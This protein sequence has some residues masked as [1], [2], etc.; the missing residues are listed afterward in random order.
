MASRKIA[1]IIGNSKYKDKTLSQLIT[2][3]ADVQALA[4][5]LQS[6]QI[7]GFEEV[8]Q[9]INRSAADVQRAIA[10]FFSGKKPGDVLLLY[11]SGHG[12]RDDR[13]DLYLALRDTESALLSGT[14]IPA[15]FITAEMDRSRSKRQ[16]LILDCCHSGAFS[17]GMKGA[18]GSSV[19]T[20]TV[21]E[22]TGSGRVV[23]TA[24]DSTQ[25][26]WEGEK[27]VGK[28][29]NS[30]FTRYLIRGLETGEADLDGDGNVGLD[31]LYDYVYE[32]V[33]E[34]TPKQTPGKWSYKQHGEFVIARNPFA[35]A[36]GPGVE[37]APRVASE[38]PPAVEKPG[39][40]QFVQ[41]ASGV[42]SVAI[43][44]LTAVASGLI[45]SNF[46]AR[47][48]PTPEQHAKDAR[49][50][51]LE[52]KSRAMQFNANVWAD[53]LFGLAGAMERRADSAYKARSFQPALLGFREANSLFRESQRVA[54]NAIAEA[55]KNIEA[56]RT[57]VASARGRAEDEQE[58]AR[59]A[60]A[61]K[62]ATGQFRIGVNLLQSA[63]SLA[64]ANSA[65]SLRMAL[66]E[67][68]K[69]RDAFQNSIR[70]LEAA[71]SLRSDYRTALTEMGNAKK[72]VPGTQREKNF[73]SNFREGEASEKAARLQFQ[74]GNLQAAAQ[75]LRDATAA[76]RTAAASITDT[77]RVRLR[78]KLNQLPEAGKKPPLYSEALK[79]EQQ[80]DA[81]GKKENFQPAYE[82]Y[83]AALL[84]LHTL[85]MMLQQQADARERRRKKIQNAIRQIKESFRASVHTGELQ[86]LAALY[87]D[88]TP[89]LE[90]KWSLF[91]KYTSARNV[92]IGDVT[93]PVISENGATLDI[94]VNLEYKDTKN[95]LKSRSERYSWSLGKQGGKWLIINFEER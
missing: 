14:A 40:Q 45:Y 43:I 37:K 15:A 2:P 11:F 30:V 95:K 35:T 46:F 69:A 87:A 1:L 53:S 74:A 52:T 38:A 47:N 5:V 36:L 32:R 39:W 83:E 41:S 19:G 66:Q 67:F 25:Y 76:Y 63:K 77:M 90:K 71:N 51:M 54:K 56:L 73:D 28:G 58:K 61:A 13:G 85:S 20:A 23:L 49:A 93:P 84:K 88:F 22:G 82:K 94:V 7:G 8:E 70:D 24:T 62:K 16:V 34:E 78:A 79:L 57:Q 44:L 9:L 10:R 31:E 72:L 4:K 6:H 80:G 17:R 18:A 3:D 91:F 21:F 33:V 92:E 27:V 12:I 48:T 50:D 68:R 89:E 75:F 64:G 29:E 60:G 42:V 86:S 55:E 59:Q 26:A 81:A 65:D